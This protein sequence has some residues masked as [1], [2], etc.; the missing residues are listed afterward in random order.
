MVLV[1][2]AWGTLGTAAEDEAGADL[3]AT[4][5]ARAIGEAS[6]RLPRAS[7]TSA[8]RKDSS[9]GWSNETGI[10]QTCRDS[11]RAGGVLVRGQIPDSTWFG[12][13]A[14]LQCLP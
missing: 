5:T 4:V 3:V 9:P 7:L 11:G 8:R 2:P 13:Y 12:A 6:L 14:P 1:S 10:S